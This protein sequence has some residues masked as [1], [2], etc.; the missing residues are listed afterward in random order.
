MHGRMSKVHL[1]QNTTQTKYNDILNNCPTPFW[2][3]RY[4][5][6]V[7]EKECKYLNDD[8]NI[9]GDDQLILSI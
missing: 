7:V 4:H 6:L 2:A 1:Q 8:V 5:S 9:G 3:V